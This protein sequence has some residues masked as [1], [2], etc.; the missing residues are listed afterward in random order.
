MFHEREKLEN[1]DFKK[2]LSEN[3]LRTP[4]TTVHSI[5]TVEG[6]DFWRNAHKNG[7]ARM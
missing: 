6:N 2:K 1:Q 3:R 4:L 5:V 7:R